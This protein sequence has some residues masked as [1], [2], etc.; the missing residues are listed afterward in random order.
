MKVVVLGAGGVGGYFGGR[1]AAEG[2][3][4]TFV[5]RGAHLDAMREKGL[6]ITSPRGDLFIPQVK[7]VAT[8]AEAGTA[9]LVLVG[10]K[11]WDTEAAAASLRPAA[12][13]GA[14]II[15]FQNGVQK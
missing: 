6:K 15:S 3:D 11:L 9:D 2:S 4:V 14:A 13:Q 10:V 8:V 1:L 12:D 5:A 7:A